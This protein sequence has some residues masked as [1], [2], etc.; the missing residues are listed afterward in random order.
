LERFVAVFLVEVAFFVGAN[1]TGL[2]SAFLA[3]GF[4]G[5]TLLATGLTGVAFL[6]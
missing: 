4:Y 3:T 6:T 2:D 5:A 1:L